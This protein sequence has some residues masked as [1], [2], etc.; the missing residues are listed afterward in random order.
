PNM[1]TGSV[2][3]KFSETGVLLAY[4][5]ITPADVEKLRSGQTLDTVGTSFVIGITDPM[6]TIN[7][8]FPA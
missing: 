3:K 5:D 1:L 4:R 2:G 7:L 6:W 8:E